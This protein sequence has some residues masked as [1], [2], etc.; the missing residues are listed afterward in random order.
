MSIETTNGIVD[1]RTLS[2][3]MPEG[4][5]SMQH[6]NRARAH[7]SGK[8]KQKPHRADTWF[9]SAWT[10]RRVLRSGLVSDA[11]AKDQL[12]RTSET[13]TQTNPTPK[14]VSIAVA[15]DQSTSVSVDGS[16]STSIQVPSESNNH[17]EYL[18]IVS[19]PPPVLSTDINED[20]FKSP[21]TQTFPSI[22]QGHGCPVAV[23]VSNSAPV[24]VSCTIH[25]HS[26]T[27]SSTAHRLESPVL[28]LSPDSLGFAEERLDDSSADNFSN[29]VYQ[30]GEPGHD[31]PGD[32]VLD[33][34]ESMESLPWG[35]YPS[36]RLCDSLAS[37]VSLSSDISI[38][39]AQ[40]HSIDSAQRR[41]CEFLRATKGSRRLLDTESLSSVPSSSSKAPHPRKEKISISAGSVAQS[42]CNISTNCIFQLGRLSV[43]SPYVSNEEWCTQ[44]AMWTCALAHCPVTIIVSCDFFS[45]SA[46]AIS[47]WPFHLSHHLLEPYCTHP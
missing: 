18:P 34:A 40:R 23:L 38:D 37:V 6:S 7:V 31:W 44:Q 10:S 43:R 19:V 29:V 3:T 12:E 32:S 2:Q 36:T 4:L 39:S 13:N 28:S 16:I 30:P 26:R 25:R 17:L 24:V 14:E 27:S 42:H 20:D 33:F 1:D 5:G 22:Q 41:N 9:R 47:L 15:A 35:S 21:V 8:E 11:V 46:E 45:N